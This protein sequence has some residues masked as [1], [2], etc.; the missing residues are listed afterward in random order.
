LENQ[1]NNSGA[2][3]LDYQFGGDYW[4]LLVI[5]QEL[6]PKPVKSGITDLEYSQ[7][8][9]GIKENDQVLIL[10]SSG[11]IERQERMQERL[12]QRMSMP[13]MGN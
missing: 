7:I 10:P 1:G 2:S 6:I 8:I 12:N 5:N 13:G 9:D 11:L 4:V 3:S